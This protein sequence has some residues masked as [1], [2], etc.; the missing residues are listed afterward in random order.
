M[1][2]IVLLPHP[3]KLTL[4]GGDI[5]LSGGRLILIDS[6]PIN[7]I[8]LSATRWQQAL[9]KRA[10][11]HW[12][13]T[14]SKAVPTELVGLTLR[15]DPNRVPYHQGYEL[16]I[17]KISIRITG[18]DEA[19][20]FYGVATLIQLLTQSTLHPIAHLPCLY[21]L[22]YP[23]FPSRGVMIDI[24]RD[25][26]PTLGTVF[27]L[28]EMLA[29]WKINQLQLYTEHTFAYRNHPE[30]WAKASPF[31]G[32]DILQ[33][34][35]FCRQRYI[36]L[37]PNQNSFGHMH[38][39]LSH[40]RYRPLAECPDGYDFPWG[41][42][43]N[44]PFTLC[45]L[46]PGSIQLIREMYDELLPHFTSKMV[47]VGCDETWDVG[48]GRSHDECAEKGTGRVY[49]DFLLKI[50][51][52][53]NARGRRM[54]FWGDIILQHPELVSELPKDAIALE[55]G[56][57]ANQPFDDHCAKF[58]AAGLDFYVCPGTSSWNTIAGRTDNALANLIEAAESGIKY[59]A[60]GYLNTDWGDSGHWQPLPVSYLGFA[61]G[62]AY[63]WS[64][65][66]N[67]DLD[68]IQALSLFAF[69][70]P[71]G[72]LGRVAYDLGNVYRVIG[73]EPANASALF[74]VLQ[75]SF[76]KIKNYLGKV[77]VE[78]IRKTL[79]AI[80]AALTP[81]AN[82]RSTSP[83][84]DLVNREF[85][86]AAH[87]LQH[88]CYRLLVACGHDSKSPA[89]LAADIDGIMREHEAVWL[90]RNRPGGLED[91]LARFQ[92]IKADYVLK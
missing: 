58:A 62:A 25:K 64:L 9:L 43:S 38:R 17:D 54:Q 3:R 33:L 47:N 63:S 14:A 11:L 67:R 55:W 45:P 5:S 36:E 84:A 88:A 23:N 22:D 18:S 44:E 90:A 46:D 32:D 28:V 13:I 81:L 27:E 76:E 56:Y 53:V 86:F 73:V 74:E 51:N 12:E 69:D 61:A 30:P 89:E 87:T 80:D 82:A 92:R 52:E 31:T 15:I 8:L 1:A 29:S 50:S 19:G 48:Q 78:T 34:E 26:V 83:D 35:A 16:L 42:H 41:G 79:Q 66:A 6:T 37:V 75:S 59:G 40:P 68:M 71:T 49:M 4:S 77:N 10:N 39:W 65:F 70:D 24:S 72:N 85:R 20:V 2:K 7:G 21:I 57:D 60:V 91:S